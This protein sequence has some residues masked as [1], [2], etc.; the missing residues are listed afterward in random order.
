MPIDGADDQ[1]PVDRDPAESVRA[2]P[3]VDAIEA[4]SSD[5]PAEESTGQALIRNLLEWVLVLVFAI[6][7]ALVVRSYLFQSFYIESGSMERTLL[8]D[9][10]VV[11]NRLSYQWGE[12]QRGQ[13]VVFRRDGAVIPGQT[14][15]LIKRVIAIGGDEVEGSGGRLTLNGVVLDEP[16]LEAGVT[17]SNF[18]PVTVPEG[19]I[20]VMGDNRNNSSDSRFFGP[21]D[22]D[23]V[24]GRAFVRYWPA[25][26]IGAP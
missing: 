15:D 21:I 26:R 18:G 19:H 4:P 24:V 8:I 1:A 16:Y 12:P 11:V 9:D 17:T 2:E 6:V 25:S 14:Q 3:T 13:I 23:R 20:W 5:T 10:K 7:I 22:I